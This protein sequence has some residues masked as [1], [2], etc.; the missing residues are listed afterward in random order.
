MS[1]N[2]NPKYGGGPDPLQQQVGFQKASEL[3]KEETEPCHK[4]GGCKYNGR[5][6]K[7]LGWFC[8]YC[9]FLELAV[10]S[11]EI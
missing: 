1:N 11:G 6:A 9:T 2:E 5:V 8:E 7:K 3:H 10:G 4:Y